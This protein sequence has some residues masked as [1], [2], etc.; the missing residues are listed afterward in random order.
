M[1]TKESINNLKD[2][3]KANCVL[4]ALQCDTFGDK[5][6]WID[7]RTSK[8]L[9]VICCDISKQEYGYAP[10]SF[11]H[12]YTSKLDEYYDVFALDKLKARLTETLV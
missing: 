2:W 5:A 3:I 12:P 7:V 9:A 4:D 11:G 10:P 6:I 1:I 8:G